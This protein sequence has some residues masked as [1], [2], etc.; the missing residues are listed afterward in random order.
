MDHIS[1]MRALCLILRLNSLLSVSEE[2]RV[3]LTRVG[4]GAAGGL[5]SAPGPKAGGQQGDQRNSPAVRLLCGWTGDPVLLRSRDDEVSG[6]ERPGT[7]TRNRGLA[8][9]ALTTVRTHFLPA[10]R[11]LAPAALSGAETNRPHGS[12]GGSACSAPLAVHC[13]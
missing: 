12:G 5:S 11:S 6:D 13:F 10:L 8:T 4:T 1:L 2:K 3:T 9:P 7:S